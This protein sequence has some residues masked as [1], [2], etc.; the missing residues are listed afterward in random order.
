MISHG[1]AIPDLPSAAYLVAGW[2][3]SFNCECEAITVTLQ[4]PSSA[5]ISSD[6]CLVSLRNVCDEKLGYKP[7][8]LDRIAALCE[9]VVFTSR[10]VGDLQTYRKVFGSEDMFPF[11]IP[12]RTAGL[13][14][15]IRGWNRDRCAP[16]HVPAFDVSIPSSFLADLTVSIDWE[17]ICRIEG[18]QVKM[19]FKSSPQRLVASLWLTQV[20]HS[21]ASSPQILP[22]LL[23]RKVISP[24]QT[25]TRP[26]RSRLVSL[27]LL[28]TVPSH[29]SK[30]TPPKH[31]C[32]FRKSL[33]TVFQSS[34]Q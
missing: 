10:Q 26:S 23:P 20:Q 19:P 21:S 14:V 6:G 1:G 25:S 32:Q 2:C 33:S 11:A 4:P 15:D 18:F 12:R 34:T 31:P 17:A 22:S 16:L 13:D 9:A 27:R 24:T 29:P 7:S 28:S 3:L 8:V 5:C 30:R